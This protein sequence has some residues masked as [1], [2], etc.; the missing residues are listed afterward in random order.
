MFFLVLGA[1]AFPLLRLLSTSEARGLGTTPLTTS[2]TWFCFAHVCYTTL[3]RA[4]SVRV[5]SHPPL[6]T[7]FG[8]SDVFF[9]CIFNPPSHSSPH[10]HPNKPN[11]AIGRTSTRSD[12]YIALQ[13]HH[14]KGGRSDLAFIDQP[15]IPCALRHRQA[16]LDLRIAVLNKLDTSLHSHAA[17]ISQQRQPNL[18]PSIS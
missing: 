2:T 16:C 3:A 18:Q 8:S 6:P 1:P 13:C 9:P 10:G 14:N 4:F 5:G 15:L 11:N 12:G 7:R 17:T